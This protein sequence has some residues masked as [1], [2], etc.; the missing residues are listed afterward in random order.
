MF[1]DLDADAVAAAQHQIATDALA[2]ARAV[3]S[4]WLADGPG[5]GLSPDEITRILVRRDV[6]NPQ[7]HRLSPFERRWAVLVIRLIRAAMD[8]TPAV[9]DAHHRGASW[10]DIGSALGVARA[11]AYK[12]FSGKVT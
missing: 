5:V 3:A 11:T 4:G 10:A 8:P 6:A 12:R 2:A 1:D 7:Y 9:A